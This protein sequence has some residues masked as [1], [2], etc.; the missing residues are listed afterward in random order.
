M[1]SSINFNRDLFWALAFHLPI[2]LICLAAVVIVLA[3]RRQLSRAFLWALSGFGLAAFLCPLSSFMYAYLNRLW[4]T[5]PNNHLGG[6]YAM[7]WLILW[8]I[9]MAASYALLLI[10]VCAGRSQTSEL[11]PQGGKE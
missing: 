8:F 5:D 9:L 1:K 3:K 2:L 6:Y 7:C 10:A 4:M 11:M